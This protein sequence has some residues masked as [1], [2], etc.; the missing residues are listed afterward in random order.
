MKCQDLMTMDLRWVS[1]TASIQEAA[2]SMRDNSIGF[3]PVCDAGGALVGVV[4]DRDLSTRAVARNYLP[5]ITTVAEVMSKPPIVCLEEE[6]VS[7]AEEVMA[8]Y[9]VARLPVVGPGNGLV[10]VISLA[11]I[12]DRRRGSEALRTARAVLARDSGG[13]HPPIEDIHLTA[14]DPA[15]PRRDDHDP[16]DS[17]SRTRD[18]GISVAIGRYPG[19]R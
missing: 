11:D 19:V 1:D 8:E 16:L 14:A 7:R 15:P 12:V 13:P 6:P 4:T 17:Y 5:S 18:E 10:G 2:V 9:Q 3:L